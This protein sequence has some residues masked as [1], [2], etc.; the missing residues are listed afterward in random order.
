MRIAVVGAGAVGL[1]YGARLARAGFEVSFLARSGAEAIQREGVRVI[2]PAGDFHLARVRCAVHP[3]ELGQADLVVIALKATANPALETLLPPLLGP[4]T[5]ILILQNG[6]GAEEFVAARW[7]QHRV[8]GGV[9]FVCLSRCSPSTVR[10]MG[11]GRVVVAEHGC[12]DSAAA[13]AVATMFATA[14]IESEAV[15]SLAAERW[16]KLAWNIPFNGLTIVSGGVGVDRVLANEELFARARRLMRETAEI[17]AAEGHP[18]S[19]DF[20]DF[21]ILRTR[22]MGPYIPSTTAD[23]LAGRELELEA[24]WGEPLRRAEAWGVHAPELLRLHTE[25]AAAAASRPQPRP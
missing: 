17:A 21:Q 4:A 11:F 22:S 25:L 3:S 10:H 2:S 23:W 16:R 14:G 24:I 12:E 13:R 5:Q 18:I 1:F 20:L 9:C 15:R 19:Q 7:P 8:L 6:L